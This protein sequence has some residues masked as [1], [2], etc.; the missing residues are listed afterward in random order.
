MKELFEQK[1]KELEK[2]TESD[3]P[4]LLHKRIMNKVAFSRFR[5]LFFVALI[6]LILD[7]SVFSF[8]SV[9]YLIWNDIVAFVGFMV[10]EFELTPD[11]LFQFLSVI[12]ENT[13]LGLIF[14][15]LLN[16]LVSVYIWRLYSSFKYALS[17][18][19]VEKN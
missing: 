7:F 8:F 2:L 19:L 4:P 18:T 16:L 9:R 3:F 15:A 1:I 11:Y 10:K 6:L 13:P 17:N 14:A 5:P 12:Y